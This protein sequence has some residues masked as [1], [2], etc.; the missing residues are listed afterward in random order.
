VTQVDR[1]AEI[2]AKLQ[3]ARGWGSDV[4]SVGSR[5]EML[6]ALADTCVAMF[7]AASDSWPDGLRWALT[8]AF[9]AVGSTAPPV[10]IAESIVKGMHA[11]TKVAVHLCPLDLADTMPD[12]RFGPCEIR[13]FSREELERRFQS[14]R[15]ERHFSE[16]RF[17]AAAF[18]QFH[19]LVVNEELPLPSKVSD[20]SFP[21]HEF[22]FSK[23]LGEI[24]PHAISRPALVEQAIFATIMLPWEDMTVYSDMEWRGFRV[25]WVYTVETDVFAAPKKPPDPATLTW[26]PDIHQDVYSGEEVETERP[27]TLPLKDDADVALKELTD[28][29]WHEIGHALQSP[30]VNPLVS[31][32]LVRAFMSDEIDEFLS[33]MIAIEA[34]LGLRDDFRKG[35][36]KRRVAHRVRALTGDAASADQYETLFEIRSA[37]VHGRELDPIPSEKRMS[38]RR[39]ARRVVDGLIGAAANSKFTDRDAFLGAL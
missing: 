29:R 3:R 38:A 8:N 24:T 39:L 11:S 16:Y 28:K 20:R 6:H 1:L 17:D 2:I 13:Q 32:F 19:W 18:A 31:H 23:D 26:Q 15:L 21:I 33:H 4:G 27:T 37:F 14:D 10:E 25:P 35:P 12:A 36:A 7:P 30:I 22:D 34:A 5:P 9:R